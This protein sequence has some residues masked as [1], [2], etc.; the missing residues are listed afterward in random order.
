M[1]NGTMMIMAESDPNLV[2]GTWA[3][4][5]VTLIGIIMTAI[6]TQKSLNQTKL[7]NELL[8]TELKTR[9]RPLFQLHN[10]KSELSG[11]NGDRRVRL[12]YTIK[13]IGTVDARKITLR[14]FESKN[15]EINNI[16]KEWND[17]KDSSFPLGT[18]QINGEVNHFDDVS[19]PDGQGVTNWIIWMEYEYFSV[20]EKCV[21]VFP[22]FTGGR[23]P[24]PF[25]WFVHEDVVEAE[26]RRDDERSGNI[27]A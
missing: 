17:I 12:R 14:S 22:G 20:K 1:I 19:W 25:T 3:L 15:T 4:V 11:P 6:Y 23:E 24:V 10:T 21:I 18:I 16:V 13:N 27:S 26:K 9:L 5:I 7:S 2:Y 8:K